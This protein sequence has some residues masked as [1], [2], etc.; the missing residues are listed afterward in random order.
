MVALE[1]GHAKLVSKPDNQEPALD[2]SES[3][4]RRCNVTAALCMAHKTHAINH[5][6]HALMMQVSKCEIYYQYIGIA[7]EE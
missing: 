4:S 7:R 5:N 6:G 2:T 3:I 1:A